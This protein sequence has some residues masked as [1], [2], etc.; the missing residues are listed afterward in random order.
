MKNHTNEEHSKP[1]EPKIIE[2]KFVV[3]S[4]DYKL[5]EYPENN[6]FSETGKGSLIKRR[7]QPI[8]QI[9]TP[10]GSSCETCQYKKSCERGYTTVF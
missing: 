10:L 4:D 8:K 1:N 5:E 9:E 3:I 6:K 7:I 2:E